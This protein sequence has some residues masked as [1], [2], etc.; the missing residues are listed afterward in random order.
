[1]QSDMFEDKD[2]SMQALEIGPQ[3]FRDQWM[4]SYFPAASHSNWRDKNVLN[5]CGCSDLSSSVE[6]E[7]TIVIQQ[8]KAS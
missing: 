5:F 4:Q 8:M 7:P 1:M 2:G 3:R 6:A